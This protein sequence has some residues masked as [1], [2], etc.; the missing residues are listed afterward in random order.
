M[1]FSFEIR[2]LIRS[3][4][5]RPNEEVLA[6]KS[7]TD[8]VSRKRRSSS[9]LVETLLYSALYLSRKSCSISLDALALPTVSLICLPTEEILFSYNQYI[10]GSRIFLTSFVLCI[11]GLFSLQRR[12]E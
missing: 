12:T 9:S 3:G 1:D 8:K 5:T 11:S 10:V 4:V 6:D 2:R 7:L